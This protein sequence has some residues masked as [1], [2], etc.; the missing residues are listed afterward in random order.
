MHSLTLIQSD[1]MHSLSL[2]PAHIPGHAFAHIH[3]LTRLLPHSDRLRRYILVHED[4]W[5]V[6]KSRYSID[7]EICVR[8][9]AGDPSSP[10]A[11]PPVISSNPRKCR[12]ASVA[13]AAAVAASVGAKQCSE[14]R[15]M[16][17][18]EES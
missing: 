8:K 16:R 12:S 1:D 10:L 18:R 14:G 3:S 7:Y 6:L 11:P 17:E 9:A 2:T 15:G 13:A 5:R 4:E